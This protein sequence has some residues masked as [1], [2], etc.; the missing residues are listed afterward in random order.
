MPKATSFADVIRA[1]QKQLTAYAR[2][3]DKLA[4]AEPQRLE[5]EALVAKA[6]ELKEKQESHTGVR[7]QTTKDITELVKAGNEV[8]RRLQ[9]HAKGVLGTA[10]ENLVDFNVTPRR[11]RGPRKAKATKQPPET[12]PPT[13]KAADGAS[14]EQPAVKPSES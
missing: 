10:N 13:V 12:P 4:A 11:Q 8:V 7:Q 9:N 5:L 6:L 14:P 1:W 3:G 2:H